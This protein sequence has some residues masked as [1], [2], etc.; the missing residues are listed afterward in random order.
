MNVERRS[1]GDTP[2]SYILDNEIDRLQLVI[3]PQSRVGVIDSLW[4]PSLGG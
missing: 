3:H 2:A 4:G 1:L